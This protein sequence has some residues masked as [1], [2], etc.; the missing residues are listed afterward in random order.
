MKK[1]IVGL[2]LGNLLGINLAHTCTR[3]TYLGPENTVITAR[4]MDWARDVGTNLWLFPRG[5]K[6]EGSAGPKSISWTSKYGSVAASFYDVAIADG[7]NEKAL[8]ANLLYLVESEYPK[9]TKNEKRLPLGIA[10]WAQYILDNFATVEEAVKALEKEPFYVVPVQTPDNEAGTAHLAISD[11]SGD[12]AIIEYLKGKLAIHHG[13]QYQVM[14]NSPSYDQQLALDAYWQQ[15]G[16]MTMLPGT[17]RAADRFA[18]ASFY[19]K[20]APQ[21]ADNQEAIAAVFSVIRN[22][23]TPMGVSEPGKPNIAPTL[24]RTVSDQK[25]K[26]YYFESIKSLN[27]FWIDLADLNFTA[28]APIKKLALGKNNTYSQNASDKFQNSKD[29]KFLSS[30]S[31]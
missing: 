22:A 8:V 31:N 15:I 14:T 13:R 18:R 12:S 21:T 24:W 27:I 5:L 10:V 17:A 11:A 1:I 30:P 19:I 6:R 29:I 2:A 25:N 7:M 28:G 20:S 23:S 26:R 3:A 9:P 4:S 16:G